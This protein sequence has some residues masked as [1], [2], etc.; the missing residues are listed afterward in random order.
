MDRITSFFYNNKI[1]K[2]KT[3]NRIAYKVKFSV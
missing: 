2:F 1:L 3:T